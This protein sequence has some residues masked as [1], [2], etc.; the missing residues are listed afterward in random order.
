MIHG[1]PAEVEEHERSFHPS[2]VKT[3]QKN[4]KFKS[5]FNQLGFRPEARRVAIES[6]MS[7]VADSGMECFTVESHASR[8]YLETTNAITFTNEDMEVEHPDHHR[9][10]FL[11]ATINDVQVRRALVDTRASLNLIILSTLEAVGLTSR[12]ILGTPMEITGFGGSG[13]SIEGYM[14]LAL[15]VGP[16][17]ALTK[18]HVINLEVSYHVLL[19]CPWLHKYCLIPSTY[20]Q[21]VKRRLNGRPIRIPTNHNPLSQGEVNFMETM[22]YSELEPDDES[23]TPGT[24]GAPILEEEEG[25]G[26]H[27]LRNLLERK[28]QKR[29]P[30]FSRSQECVVVR[31]P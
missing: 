17:V 2:I 3:F 1:N 9:P 30:S 15:R 11:M 21:C 28:R 7:I 20:H 6:F 22:F 18:F 24:P 5:L 26:T 23:P 19:G 10:L 8:A 29:E 16:I 4:P 25:G 14:Q 27:D 31:E 13:E 12:R